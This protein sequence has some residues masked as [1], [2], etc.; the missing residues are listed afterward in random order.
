[1]GPGWVLPLRP[2]PLPAL[3]LSEELKQHLTRTLA[4]NYRQPGAVDIT[5]SVDRLQQDVS[6]CPMGSK[7]LQTWVQI[8]TPSFCPCSPGQ[9][10]Y[11]L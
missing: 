7:P 6:T 9:V 5:L 3:Q 2:P 11:L 1:M 4:E 10:T 8:P